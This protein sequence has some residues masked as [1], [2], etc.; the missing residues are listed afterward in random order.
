MTIACVSNEVGGDL[1]GN[2]KWT[3]VHLR[4]VL[5]M[6]GVQAGG[7][8]RS[9]AARSTASRSASRP[10][11]AMDPARDPMIAIG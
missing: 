6:A 2:A 4:D 1:V 5:A 7:D 9:S 8:A 11:W 10:A 3:G